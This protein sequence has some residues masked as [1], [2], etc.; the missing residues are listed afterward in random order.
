M[1]IQIKE[2]NGKIVNFLLVGVGGQGTLLASDILADM[3][4]RLGLDVKKAE[5]HGMSQRGGT[6]VSHLRWGEQVFSP[7]I[8][9]GEVDVLISFEKMETLRFLSFVKPGGLIL[10]NDQT[11]T[12]VTVSSGAGTYPTDEIVSAQIATVSQNWVWVKA[13]EIAEKAG[14]AR[15]A[16]VVMLG[17]LSQAFDIDEV[18][19]ETVIKGRLA[20]KHQ[21]VNLRAF[22]AGRAINPLE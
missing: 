22:T 21:Q 7:I 11:I 16:N 6:V 10:V 19:W 8:A 14:S 4:L 2:L 1:R 17:A 20:E 18:E 9:T 5:V 3:A 12:P 15:A 13:A